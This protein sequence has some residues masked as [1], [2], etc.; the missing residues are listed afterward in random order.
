MSITCFELYVIHVLIGPR[1]MN[2][3][4]YRDQPKSIMYSSFTFNRPARSMTVV[5]RVY[6]N[7]LLLEYST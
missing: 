1:V 3:V 7:T 2:G 4:A 5:E 6:F